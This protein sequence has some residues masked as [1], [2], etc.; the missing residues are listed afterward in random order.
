MFVYM[1]R[2]TVNGKMYIGQTTRDINSRLQDHKKVARYRNTERKYFIHKAIAKHGWEAFDKHVLEV[3]ESQAELDAAESF[4]IE[5]YNTIAPN[6]Y[7]LKTGGNGGCRY[8]DEA[9][10]KLSEA[11]RNRVP[12]TG[13]RH[14]EEAKRKM[15]EAERSNKGVPKPEEWKNA[16]SKARIENG[17]SAGDKNPG[18]KLNWEIVKEIRQRYVNGDDITALSKEFNVGYKTVWNIVKNKAWVEA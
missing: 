8:S 13:W 18:A 7:N 9:R 16:I 15:S 1:L 6:G 3:C 14:T 10:R 12:Y 17:S 2:N 4:W 11:A 5:R